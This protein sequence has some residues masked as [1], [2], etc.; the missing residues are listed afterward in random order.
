VNSG[1]TGNATA[2]TLDQLIAL[3]DEMAALVRAG[4]PLEETLAELGSEV[5]GRLGKIAAR[6][7][8]RMRAGE[9]LT[10]ILAGDDA[11]FPPVW[12]AVV[13]A[14]LRCG[15]LA[16]ALEAM[17]DTGYRLAELRRAVGTALIYPLM[18]VAVAYGFFVLLVTTLAPVTLR[19]YEDLTSS[20]D[21]LLA[22]LVWL[23]QTAPW[24]APFPPL[25]V[26]LVLA[27]WWYRSGRASAVQ[28][29][30][31]ASPGSGRRGWPTAGRVLRDGRLATFAEIL[32]LLVRQQVPMPEAVVLAADASGDRRLAQ[33]ARDLADRL[34]SGGSGA[35][36]QA[37]PP[38]FPPLVGW[39][40]LSG[41]QA[42]VLGDT[43]GQMAE[44][45][46]QRA[47][48]TTTWAGVYL[49]MLLTAVIG[50][51]ATLLQALLV[52]GPIWKML[53]DLGQAA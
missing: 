17:S 2:V 10:Q 18:V 43:L 20:S 29:R 38:H 16:A 53:Y 6:L 4:V 44:T 39:L 30:T 26:L 34:R 32:S 47:A 51:T 40:I 28:G 45:Y 11:L 24:W 33:G 5:P 31:A 23:G 1:A 13:Q 27:V 42:D 3:N 35:E 7:G 48:R 25:V 49:P 37:M 12:R 15:R 9:S 21:P 50:G 8:Q 14:G 46:R 36:G 19:T 22:S 52:F 41:A